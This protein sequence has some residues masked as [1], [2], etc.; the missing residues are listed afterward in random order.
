MKTSNIPTT[1]ITKTSSNGNHSPHIAMSEFT[2]LETTPNYQYPYT[3]P[4]NATDVAHT[5]LSHQKLT[6]D[7][8]ID[9]LT[10]KYCDA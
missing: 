9:S 7:P 10:G 3:S 4:D 8:N 1:L 6:M 2:S 5:T